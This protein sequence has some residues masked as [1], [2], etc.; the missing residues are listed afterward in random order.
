M[1]G[2]K[3][4]AKIISL[5]DLIEAGVEIVAGLIKGIVQAVVGIGTLL[6]NSLIKPLIDAVKNLLGIH[7]PSTVFAEIGENL[8][9]GLL[10]GIK[11]SW[12]GILEFFKG[13]VDAI[14][15]F[16]S[17][18]WDTVKQK[19]SESWNAIKE[20]VSGIWDSIKEKAGAIFDGIKEKIGAV[21]DG[22]KEKTSTIWENIKTTLGTLW[23]GL[24][25]KVGTIF[26]GIK[27]KISTIWD[28]IK[29]KTTEIWN[30]IKTTL[31][32]TW[33]NLKTW[34]KEKFDNIKTA[35]TT[36]WDNVKAKTTEI[37]NNIKSTL[38]TLW[39]ELKTTVTTVFTAIKNKISE[40]W[41]NV[42]TAASQ[43][44][45]E[46]KTTIK[47]KWEAIR[48]E[49]KAKFEEV[50]SKIS[51]AWDNIKRDIPG[52]LDGIKS[53]I[54]EKWNGIVSSAKRWGSDL[55]DNLAS[56]IEG[57]IGTVK[58]AARGVADRVS[59]YLHFSEPDVGPLS[60]FHTYMPD[61]LQ[62]MAKGIRD[63]THLAVSAASDLADSIANTVSGKSIGV[64]MTMPDIS[65]F[66]IPAVAQGTKLPASREF[67]MV[68]QGENGS[69][70][71]LARLERL[72]Q[73]MLERM[74]NTEIIIKN[75]IPLD[76]KVIARNTVRHI[77]DFTRSAGRPVIDF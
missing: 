14:K 59:E 4:L 21:W 32:T 67:T 75:E 58:R 68:M 56:G 63:N 27:E 61:M 64:D 47:G 10:Q 53:A 48:D 12:N 66:S 19:T 40:I 17:G 22:L 28:N 38:T 60:D 57:A 34:A 31:S 43:K 15:E 72:M 35:I 42:K 52:K 46:I 76:G 71:S 5:P 24:K 8:G 62:L 74:G 29:S 39:N 69:G 16:F 44:W 3:L 49:A 36:A 13:G 55:C 20:T 50:R 1:F 51:E 7:S 65:K 70:D 77:N 45:E 18:A 33:D 23:D 2:A 11:E 41:D 30:N 9:A 37:W 26:D 25:E 54:Q 6:Y 73:N